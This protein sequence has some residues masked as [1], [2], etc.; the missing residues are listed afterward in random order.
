VETSTVSKTNVENAIAPKVM[1][2]LRYFS[3]ITSVRK[4]PM[5]LP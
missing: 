1:A 4:L 2:K 5:P 3:P